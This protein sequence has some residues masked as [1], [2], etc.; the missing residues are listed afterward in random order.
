MK[1]EYS[2]QPYRVSRDDDLGYEVWAQ[3]DKDA[4]IFVC[5]ASENMDD[6]V[7]EADT[8]SDCRQVAAHWFDELRSM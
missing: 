6:F 8:P 1:N 3:Y 2:G 4:D 5:C 7:G